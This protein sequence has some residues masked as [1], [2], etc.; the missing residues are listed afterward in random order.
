MRYGV[1]LY[2]V[3]EFMKT[4]A[5]FA[6]TMKRFSAMGFKYLHVSGMTKE[7]PVEEIA[8]T[9]EAYELIPIHAHADPKRI[10]NETADVIAEHKLMRTKYVGISQIPKD[11]ER[12]REGFRQFCT[13][14]IPPA[15]TMKKAGLELVYHNHHLEFEKFEGKYAIEFMA[16]NFKDLGF[17]LNTYW[18]QM[19]GCDSADWIKRLGERVKILHLKDCAVRDGITRMCAPLEGNMNWSRIMEAAEE[20]GVRYGFVGID[21]CEDP[22]EA[23]R[24]GMRNL[25]RDYG[26][27]E[28]LFADEE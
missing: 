10:L 19:A 4:R 25:K 8:E 26:R 5:D 6:G 9:S 12:N 7:I 22:F 13:D 2:T 17:A 3:R 16:E 24:I 27:L 14:F 18:I 15:R 28:N 11:Y 21:D 23:L 20:A 1:Q